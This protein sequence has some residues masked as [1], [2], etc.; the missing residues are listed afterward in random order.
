MER[1]SNKLVIWG[2]SHQHA[3][4]QQTSFFSIV[5]LLLIYNQRTQTMQNIWSTTKC[6]Y[7]NCIV[8]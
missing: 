4:V 1:L 5:P 6:P 3:C 2:I 8:K 7:E